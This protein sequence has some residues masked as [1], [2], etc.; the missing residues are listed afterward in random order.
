MSHPEHTTT[1]ITDDNFLG[2]FGNKK[3]KNRS[4]E[5]RKKMRKE[6]W[7]KF[8]KDLEGNIKQDSTADNIVQLIKKKETVNNKNEGDY[9]IE[10]ADKETP[11]EKKKKGIPTVVWI[12]GGA[13]I[14][15]VTGIIIYKNIQNKTQNAN[16][17]TGK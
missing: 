11:E 14:A 16:T 6:R 17:H 2:L 7:R 3:N 10:I 5:E 9:K 12:V 13:T 4:K 15:L 1:A 8:W